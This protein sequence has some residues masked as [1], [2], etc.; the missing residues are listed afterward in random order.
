METSVCIASF[1][2][3]RFIKEQLESI[4]R[5]TVLPSEIIISDDGSTDKTEDIVQ[6]LFKMWEH[7]PIHLLYIRNDGE[8]GVCGNFQN[9]L[10]H[11]N[12]DYVFFCDQDDI[13]LENKIESVLKV[14]K[15]HNEKVVIHDAVVLKENKDATFT[16]TDAHLLKKLPYDDDGVYKLNG[17]DYAGYAFF[18]I[19]IQGMCISAERNWLLSILPFSKGYNHDT[20][21]LYCAFLD[22]TIVSLHKTLTLYRIHKNNTC[23]IG[24][25]NPKRSVLNKINTFDVQGK[26][27][28][29]GFYLWF[30]DTMNYL[31]CN[32]VVNNDFKNAIYE[33]YIDEI[34][35]FRKE[36][37]RYL[38]TNKIA[39]TVGIVKGYHKGM[40][41]RNGTILFL[42]DLYYL[43]MHLKNTRILYHRTF[44]NEL[45]NKNKC[46]LNKTNQEG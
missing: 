36:R 17:P 3:E 9:A 21:V 40:Y 20:W 7:L 42:H 13:W 34:D 39:G 44:E 38:K 6:S 46:N 4:I 22:N 12:G 23:G 35:Y 33:R 28:V 31:E 25:Y 15:S 8:H 18:R 45:R 10:V 26:R 16:I 32:N 27:S 24:D 2:G 37:P 29:R 43:W 41:K 5:Q 11:A 19:Y 14:F 1:N 30:N